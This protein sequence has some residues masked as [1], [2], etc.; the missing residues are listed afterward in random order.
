MS[1][2]GDGAAVQTDDRTALEFSGPLAVFAGDH[3]QSRR[4]APCAARR[5]AKAAGRGTRA[6]G[7]DRVAMAR[8]RCDDDGGRSLRL[9]LSRLHEGARSGPDRQ[10]DAGR[11][12]AC[13]SSG[14]S[15]GRCRAAASRRDSDLRELSRLRES[16]LASFSACVA[17]SMRPTAV[18]TAATRLAPADPAAWEQLASL[19]ADRGDAVR[20]G[21]S[22]GGA[23]SRV[24]AAR[25]ELVLR[26]QRELPAR[27][28]RPPRFRSCVAP[29]NWTRATLTPTTCSARFYGTAGDIGAGRDAFR[30]SLRLDPRDAVTY[31]NLAQL[32]LAA[33]PARRRGRLVR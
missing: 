6:H 20:L 29:S 16:A 3:D 1:R 32:E 11:L 5:R 15:R 10:D 13:S 2:Y 33:R 30:T 14:A 17:V 24:S 4:H 18:A 25:G 8:P 26:R 21:A 22:S 7:R 9:L 28:P 19:H 27:R 12:R 23:A 31:V